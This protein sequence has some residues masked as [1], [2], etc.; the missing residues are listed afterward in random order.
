MRNNNY[1]DED[2]K[3]RFHKVARI[4]TSALLVAGLTLAGLQASAGL[5]DYHV[6][7]VHAEEYNEEEKVLLKKSESSG[8]K[9]KGYLD[10][11]DVVEEVMPSIVSISTKSVQEVQDY[12]S[13][14]GFRGGYA[15][16]NREYE[17]EGGGSGIIVG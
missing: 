6:K 5:S 3:K 4:G 9:A 17:V 2:S 12:F 8:S 13:M 10:V 11:S 14:F 15:P 7:D 16:I 1:F